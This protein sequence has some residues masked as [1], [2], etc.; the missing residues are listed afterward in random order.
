M[1]MLDRALGDPLARSEA[2]EPEAF[3]G[4]STRAP[5]A[6]LTAQLGLETETGA[7]VE[8]VVKD[9]PAEKAGLQAHDVLLKL[10]QRTIKG[11]ED[12]V[13]QIRK[14]KKG[15]LVKLEIIRAGKTASLEATLAQRTKTDWKSLGPLP[16]QHRVVPRVEVGPA[17]DRKGESI[18]VLKSP[19]QSLVTK[20]VT[21]PGGS[22]TAQQHQSM[23]QHHTATVVVKS[24]DGSV[25]VNRENG[26]DRV[27][28]K[29]PQDEVVFE[30]PFN[31]D[32]EKSKAPAKVR[33]RLE[34]VLKEIQ[35][36]EPSATEIEEIRLLRPT[37]T[38]KFIR[39]ESIRH[40]AR[41]WL[42]S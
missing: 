36:D 41:E 32:Q 11:P 35:L 24:D 25:T 12:L 15:D 26:Q 10:D 37:T 17:P 3:L 34:K 5:D 40:S 7:L 13:R 42:R 16:R 33:E 31:T 2:A 19:G 9:S 4:V 22:S 38:P 39:H 14:H 6:S 21:L 18:V 28:V 27:V 8:T 23:Q 20:T 30:G 29:D 1:P